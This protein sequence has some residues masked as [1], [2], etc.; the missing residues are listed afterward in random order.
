MGVYITFKKISPKISHGFV[1]FNGKNACGAGTNHSCKCRSSFCLV[2]GWCR[3][4]ILPEI[5]GRGQ[6]QVTEVICI[7]TRMYSEFDPFLWRSV[8]NTFFMPYLSKIKTSVLDGFS[9]KTCHFCAIQ[10]TP[11]WVKVWYPKTPP[12]RPMWFR[13]R[14]RIPLWKGLLLGGV[15]RNP[16]RQNYL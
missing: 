5:Q 2:W 13:F 14:G 8:L 16:N 4:G 12:D 6:T 9:G 3:W 15:P 7:L 1:F 10:P 11:F